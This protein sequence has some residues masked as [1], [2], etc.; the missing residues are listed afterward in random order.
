MCTK[1]EIDLRDPILQCNIQIKKSKKKI[2][3]R[4]I[5]TSLE[6]NGENLMP[7]NKKILCRKEKTKRAKGNFPSYFFMPF[8]PS[9][10]S[11]TRM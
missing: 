3:K 2:V 8:N 5:Q 11:N 4:P 1:D 9:Y 10:S 7:F 6:K